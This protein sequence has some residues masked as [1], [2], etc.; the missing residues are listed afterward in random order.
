MPVSSKL[1]TTLNLSHHKIS[2]P[3]STTGCK[4]EIIKH[5]EYER[6][7]KSLFIWGRKKWDLKE[8]MADLRSNTKPESGFSHHFNPCLLFFSLMHGLPGWLLIWH[9][10]Y[11]KYGAFF[12][13]VPMKYDNHKIFWK[14]QTFLAFFTY[15]VYMH[16]N[17]TWK[18]P[19]TIKN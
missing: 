6:P 18:V 16:F 15:I 8:E 17:R 3:R 10:I 5:L 9:C 7:Q 1:S 11:L 14:T 2:S 19:N 12:C 13:A 4:I